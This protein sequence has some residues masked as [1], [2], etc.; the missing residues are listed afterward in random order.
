MIGTKPRLGSSRRCGS[1]HRL[2]VLD[3]DPAC[4]LLYTGSGRP[5]AA[6]VH[7]G[8]PF[9]DRSPTVP[10]RGKRVL[11]AGEQGEG[12]QETMWQPTRARNYEARLINY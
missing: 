6:V 7:P 8:D 2:S 11:V 10:A 1:I 9:P 3:P 4:C 5:R 12:G